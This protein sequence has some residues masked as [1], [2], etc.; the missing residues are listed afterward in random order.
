[1]ANVEIRPCVISRTRSGSKEF[2]EIKDAETDQIINQHWEIS[3]QGK[4]NG[5]QKGD[6]TRFFK[7]YATNWRDVV[8]KKRLSLVETGLFFSLLSFLDWESPYLLHPDT[9]KL[10]S[11]SGIA[12][13][14][15]HDRKHVDE[16]LCRLVEKGMLAKV[17][18][19]IGHSCAYM[20]NSNLV[21]FGKYM[22]D[23]ND[24]YNF[25]KCSYEPVI[26]TMYHEQPKK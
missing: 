14:I 26:K 17:N 13:L 23:L 9:H 20:L 16:I 2:V 8:A 12:H 5:H 1:M 24:H 10:L 4:Y 6:G 7:V 18:C 22:K 21:H 15:G 19:G 11:G 25:E 3:K